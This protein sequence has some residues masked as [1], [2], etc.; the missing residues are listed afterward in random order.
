MSAITNEI[1]RLSA[2]MCRVNALLE[3]SEGEVTE[4]IN[5]QLTAIALKKGTMVDEFSQLVK[6][7]ENH[8]EAIRAEIKR[9]QELDKN[10]Q[11]VIETIKRWLIR[12]MEENGIES[13][14]GDFGAVK[15]SKPRESIFINE[16]TAEVYHR[17][18]LAEIA[19]ILPRYMKAKIEYSK[20]T[21]KEDLDKGIDYPFASRMYNASLRIK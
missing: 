12:F 3:E 21:I 11:K 20:T 15:L 10:R 8:H 18:I 19:R 14:E 2:D 13:I 5:D 4:E 1:Y 9:L 16:E 7:Q 17:E 6:L